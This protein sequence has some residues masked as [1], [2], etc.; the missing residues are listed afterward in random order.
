M[1]V[2]TLAELCQEIIHGQ[3]SIEFQLEELKKSVE[4]LLS[5]YHQEGEQKFSQDSMRK[6]EIGLD[7]GQVLPRDMTIGDRFLIELRKEGVKYEGDLSE[8]DEEKLLTGMSYYFAG[9]RKIKSRRG[10]IKKI[11][12][13]CP[14]RITITDFRDYETPPKQEPEP[15]GESEAVKTSNAIAKA[16]EEFRSELTD[17][18]IARIIRDTPVF[19][20]LMKNVE[21]VRTHPS[22]ETICL[23]KAYQSGYFV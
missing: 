14:H 5:F 3:S 1:A 23:I 7:A 10:Y 8:F 12:E 16:A 19:V 11:L 4:F 6:K 13:T 17:E 2:K 15:Q 21:H 22:I 9:I 18:M 20:Q